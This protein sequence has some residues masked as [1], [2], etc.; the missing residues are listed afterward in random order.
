RRRLDRH[1]PDGSDKG[2][3]V[4]RLQRQRCSGNPERAGER[5]GGDGG[6][7][8]SRASPEGGGRAF[9]QVLRRR[10]ERR[11]CAFVHDREPD[12][13][14]ARP[15]R[16]PRRPP[17]RLR[18]REERDRQAVHRVGVPEPGH[19]GWRAGGVRAGDATRARRLVVVRYVGARLSAF[20]R[21]PPPSGHDTVR[22]S[23]ESDGSVQYHTR[24]TV[25]DSTG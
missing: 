5:R 16:G 11:T 7:W 6:P 10:R 18:E 20:A 9:G 19:R 12:G 21:S 4:R 1:L 17:W 2:R 25:T 24:S 23:T 14:A 22:T 3:Q 8:L 13:G 15:D